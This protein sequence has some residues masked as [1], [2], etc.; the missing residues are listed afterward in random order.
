MIRTSPDPVSDAPFVDCVIE[1]ERWEGIDL[2]ALA[3]EAAAAAFAHLDLP[4]AWEIS[5]LGCDDARI[6]SLNETF[7]GKGKATNVLSWPSEERAPETAGAVPEP[8]EQDGDP[9]LGDIAISYDTCLAEADAVCMP[10]ADHVRHLLVHAML[11][12][13][14]YDHETDADAD[15]MERLE[16]E[17]LATLGLPDPYSK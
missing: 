13:L 1:D 7:R 4:G 10:V 9:E 12:L 5:V 16:V 17:V 6:A 3:C 8:P 14:G 2:P 15:L 11:H